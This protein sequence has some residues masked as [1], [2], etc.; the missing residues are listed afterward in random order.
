MKKLFCG[1]LILTF[2]CIGC[3]GG[4]NF[5]DSNVYVNNYSLQT[6]DITMN[7]VPY[8][9]LAPGGTDTIESVEP[10]TYIINATV[11]G[12]GVLYAVIQIDDWI[13]DDYTVNIH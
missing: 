4:S 6:L 12:T 10:G 5:W 8:F 11:T 1:L 3:G 2:F 13:D 7:A 9:T